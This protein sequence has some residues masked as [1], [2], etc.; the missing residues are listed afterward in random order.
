MHVQA[1]TPDARQLL[2]VHDWPGNVRELENTISNAMIMCED[3]VIRVRDLP[4]RIR[5]EAERESL[6]SGRLAL[7]TSCDLSKASLFEAVKDAIEKLEKK[8]IAMRLAEMK[9]NRMA[10]AESLGISRKSLFNK[11]RQ[12]GMDDP[13]APLLDQNQ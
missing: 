8:M 9:G 4:P 2:Q 11:M 5:G 12:Y 7:T 1:I 3:D 13:S 6:G 10:T